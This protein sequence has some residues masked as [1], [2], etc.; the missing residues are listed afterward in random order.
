MIRLFGEG[1]VDPLFWIR[2][3][4]V[5]VVE[6]RQNSNVNISA[7]TNNRIKTIP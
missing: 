4:I 6:T 1:Y 2:E 7:S 5:E 3:E